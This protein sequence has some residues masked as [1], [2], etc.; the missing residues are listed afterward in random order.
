[1]VHT[2]KEHKKSHPVHPLYVPGLLKPTDVPGTFTVDWS[3]ITNVPSLIPG[4]MLDTNTQEDPWL[5]PGPAGVAGVAGAAG[6]AG[7]Q[8]PAYTVF[9]PHDEYPD[10]PFLIPGPQGPAGTAGAPGAP[11]GGGSS[12]VFLPTLDD[13][14]NDDTLVSL[15]AMGATGSGTPG[16]LTKWVNG[17]K[18]IIDSLLSEAGKVITM[19]AGANA[20]AFVLDASAGFVRDL[21]FSSAGVVRWIFRANL[22]AEGG[23]NA[24]S[25]FVINRRDDAGGDLGDALTITR[26]SGVVTLQTYVFASQV[27]KTLAADLSTFANAQ[28]NL[29][30]LSFPIGINEVWEV[31]VEIST[32]MVLA[33]GVKFYAT[34]PAGVSGEIHALA[35]T[36]AATAYQ[37]LYQAVITVPGT[38]LNTVAGSG[39]YRMRLTVRTGATAGTIQIVGIT[40][41][42]TTTCA[43]L[44]GS[45]MKATRTT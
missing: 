22:T 8:G 25:D 24:G 37:H 40:G 4:Q 30:G 3:Q 9:L 43:V 2:V 41:G 21:R 32:T 35:S 12:V 11:G 23:A 44:K 33:T 29:A 39:Y 28:T 26:S 13:Q 16:T 36:T 34:G 17:G 18:Q 14:F 6:A 19:A 1:M 10:E 31:I 15:G 20:M 5:I 27:S 38:F 45:S 42:A 7:P